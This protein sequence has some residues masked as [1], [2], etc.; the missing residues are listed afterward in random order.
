[1]HMQ[2]KKKENLPYVFFDLLR[3]VNQQPR[4]ASSGQ[5]TEFSPTPSLYSLSLLQY[6]SIQ[7][8]CAVLYRFNPDTIDVQQ[9]NTVNTVRRRNQRTRLYVTRITSAK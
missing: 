5:Y 1:M 3:K 9:P 8:V 2:A 6:S 4:S 7:S